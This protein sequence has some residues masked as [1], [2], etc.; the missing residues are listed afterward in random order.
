MKKTLIYVGL[1]V[2][3]IAVLFAISKTYRSNKK[4]KKT[5]KTEQLVK[6]NIVNKVV[7]TGE[8]I[9]EEEVERK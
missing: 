8:I 7:A 3:A 9:P 2:L 4:V 1:G 5:F 6:N